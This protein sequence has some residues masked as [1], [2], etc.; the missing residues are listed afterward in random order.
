MTNDS[1]WEHNDIINVKLIFFIKRSLNAC[2]LTLAPRPLFPTPT[3]PGVPGKSYC[4]K[5][6]PGKELRFPY[7]FM[8]EKEGNISLRIFYLLP[9]PAKILRGMIFLLSWICD[10]LSGDFCCIHSATARPDLKPVYS[11]LIIKTYYVTSVK[12]TILYHFN[13]MSSTRNR[14]KN[15]GKQCRFVV[16]PP[17]LF[18]CRGPIDLPNYKQSRKNILIFFKLDVNRRKPMSQTEFFSTKSRL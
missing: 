10:A 4:R 14:I 18:I 16:S 17:M 1:V 9:P 11:T 2:R 5:I 6:L 15:L 12:K 7:E 3:I 13:K 8:P